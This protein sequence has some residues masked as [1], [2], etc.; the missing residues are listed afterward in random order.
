VN[1][2]VHVSLCDGRQLATNLEALLIVFL[3]QRVV[4]TQQSATQEVAHQVVLF[5]QLLLL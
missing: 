5:G 1:L 4:A 3:G 2:L